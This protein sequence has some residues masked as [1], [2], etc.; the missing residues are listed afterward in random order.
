MLKQDN[1]DGCEAEHC[2]YH[3]CRVMFVHVPDPVTFC[4]IDTRKF[5]AAPMSVVAFPF[6]TTTATIASTI[7][8]IRT[9]W[10]VSIGLFPVRSASTPGVHTAHDMGAKPICLVL[11]FHNRKQ[12]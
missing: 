6:P 9:F 3:H 5:P 10:L 11:L 1:D 7:N 4:V 2:H 8:P 12:R